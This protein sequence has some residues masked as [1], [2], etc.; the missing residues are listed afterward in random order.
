MNN[1]NLLIEK[2]DVYHITN[3]CYKYH[4][5]EKCLIYIISNGQ[6]KHKM[7][8]LIKLLNDRI[9][10]V[11]KCNWN[12][13]LKEIC[14]I[15]NLEI[16]K[17]LFNYLEI[18]KISVNWC[19]VKIFPTVSNNVDWSKF[20][21]DQILI[22]C[23][24]NLNSDIII[25]EYYNTSRIYSL[26]NVDDDNYFIDV[27]VY[28]SSHESKLY[29][30]IYN[31]WCHPESIR[32]MSVDV[33]KWIHIK[34]TDP[35]S[36]Y[37]KGTNME[38]FL[39]YCNSVTLMSG[40][41]QII[42]YIINSDIVKSGFT[43]TKSED[44][45]SDIYYYAIL[46]GDLDMVK[47]YYHSHRSTWNRVQDILGDS[48][49]ALISNN[50]EMIKYIS[51]DLAIKDFNFLINKYEINKLI[52]L[53]SLDIINYFISRSPINTDNAIKECLNID[54]FNKIITINNAIMFK[55]LLK[56]LIKLNIYNI[57]SNMSRFFESL[58]FYEIKN[59]EI[60]R[61]LHKYK[62]LFEDT[63]QIAQTN[64][65][66]GNLDIVDH[67]MT[68]YQLDYNKLKHCGKPPISL[69]V[70]Q[71]AVGWLNSKLRESKQDCRKLRRNQI[72]QNKNK[73]KK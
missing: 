69:K 38:Q 47:K 49:D 50:L 5:L 1:F 57:N 64:L 14:R 28:D 61:I 63:Y 32:N 36:F 6:I 16:A 46:S 41:R 10:E 58:W 2:Y 21:H 51:E 17:W 19:P 66:N 20:I 65:I 29:K 55:W 70:P 73:N 33:L 18:K 24:N 11:N 12:N 60:F 31:C 35:K 15:R 22:N 54:T 3:R 34:D 44:I 40:N 71:Y 42:D 26:V 56:Y 48:E 67:V 13:V 39:R 59:V 45:D 52:T 72:K 25:N 43:N 53:G 62:I 8:Y 7:S 30:A 37:F 68:T 27:G 9:N 23:H 4:N